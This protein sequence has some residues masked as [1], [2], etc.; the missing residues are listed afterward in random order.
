MVGRIY[1]ENVSFEFSVEKVGVM[2]ND[3]GDDVTAE[4]ACIFARTT[5]FL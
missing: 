3:S 5:Q 2:D 4:I 1:K